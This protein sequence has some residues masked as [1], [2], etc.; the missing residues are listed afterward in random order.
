MISPKLIHLL[1]DHWEAVSARFCRQLRGEP[2]LTHLK[3]LPESE[4]NETCKKLVSNIGHY[5]TLRQTTGIGAE[6]ERVGRDRFREGIPLSEAIRGLQILK[7]AAVGYLRDQG[8]FDT[9]VDIYAEEEME[10][11]IGVF[12][13]HLVYHLALGYE[14][15]QARAAAV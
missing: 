14:V 12:F 15:A 8:L 13:D 3:K 10:H 9:S 4:L 6:Y 7:E 1:E 2:G 5:L 11:Q